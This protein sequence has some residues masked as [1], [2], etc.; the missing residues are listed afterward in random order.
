MRREYPSQPIVGIGAIIVQD[1]KILLAKR[2]SEPGKG[3]WSVPGGVVELGEKLEK[4]VVREVKEETNLDVEVV[5][6]IDA[7]SNI[8]QDTNG[9]LHFHFVILDYLTKLK[10]GTLQSSSDI[11]D[12]K[13]VNLEEADDYDITETFREFLKK[14]KNDLKKL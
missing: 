9:K 4:A 14:N 10:G 1:G 8:V 12:T 2:G 11:L 3:K 13:W 6:L 5:H 7:V